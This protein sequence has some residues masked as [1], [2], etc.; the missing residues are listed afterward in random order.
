MFSVPFGVARVCSGFRV[1]DSEA[2]ERLAENPNR[3]SYYVRE[4]AW[5]R[6]ASRDEAE[7]TETINIPVLGVALVDC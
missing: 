1:Y 7:R 3:I 5:W 2:L 6:E 4:G